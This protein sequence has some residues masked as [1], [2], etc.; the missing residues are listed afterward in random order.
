[1]MIR[2]RPRKSKPAFHGFADTLYAYI[3]GIAAV[4]GIADATKDWVITDRKAAV[5]MLRR[6]RD[7]LDEWISFLSKS[8]DIGI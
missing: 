2:T 4:G 7:R 3:N 6:V 1:M 8:A 5:A